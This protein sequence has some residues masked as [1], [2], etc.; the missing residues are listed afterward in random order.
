MSAV[1][2]MK[3]LMHKDVFDAAAEMGEREMKLLWALDQA[4]PNAVGVAYLMQLLGLTWEPL[5]GYRHNNAMALD[6][7]IKFAGVAARVARILR[8]NGWLMCRSGGTIND[9]IWIVRQ[10]DAPE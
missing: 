7:Y 2:K 5:A 6:R 10:S 8:L 1:T 9:K 4:R 3:R